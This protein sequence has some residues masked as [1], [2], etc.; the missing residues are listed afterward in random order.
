MIL[1]LKTKCADYGPLISPNWLYDIY[2][3]F[4]CTHDWRLLLVSWDENVSVTI[5][6]NLSIDFY[7]ENYFTMLITSNL[8][9]GNSVNIE[10]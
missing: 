4:Y 3:T 5:A 6:V 7:Y 10:R 2:T 8:I 1:L 9:G